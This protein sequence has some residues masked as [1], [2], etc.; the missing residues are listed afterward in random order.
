MKFVDEVTI[1]VTGG[2]GGNGCV[3][4]R[5][6]KFVPRGGPDGGDGGNGGSVFL[7]GNTSLVTLYDLKLKPHYRA[8]RG[9]HG[10]GKKMT[11]KHGKDICIN[12]PCGVVVSS[13]DHI[14]GEILT[15][16][17]ILLVAHGGKGGRGNSHFASSAKRTPRYAEEGGKGEIRT[18]KI[19]LKLIS[20][21]GLVGLPNSGKST[22]LRALT[23]AQPK[24]GDYP[25]TT[26]NPNLGVLK[27]NYRRIIV[28][29]L[30][31]IVEGAHQGKGLGHRFLRHIERTRVL[32]FV[33]DNTVN[34]PV[35]QYRS[36]LDEFRNF[37]PA[38]LEK[39]RVVVFNKID[40]QDTI[41]RYSLDEAVFYVSALYGT[42]IDELIEYLMNENKV[43]TR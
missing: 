14:I 28:A 30:P 20:D 12:V 43:Q 2:N 32:V 18:M 38:L 13:N 40:L 35:L 26:L 41:P 17:E 33:L 22:L 37:N 39:P 6:E 10:K 4:F 29:D 7:K 11:G 3:S 36:I 15:D 24:I 31:G 27:N 8:G 23:N 1:Y 9:N 19:I 5:R 25:F 42:N 34:N 21:I 16:R